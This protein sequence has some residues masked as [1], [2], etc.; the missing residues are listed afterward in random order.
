VSTALGAVCESLVA[1]GALTQDT[2]IRFQPRGLVNA[3]NLCFINSVL[4]AVLGSGAFCAFLQKLEAAAPALSAESVP[5]LAGLATLA[6]HFKE[7]GDGEEESD[8]EEKES[9][10]SDPWALVPKKGN[11]WA[12]RAMSLDA[13]P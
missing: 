4:Q 12:V 7:V 5:T 13:C 11:S 1:S 2:G 9:E 10:K 6:S 8:G 3:G